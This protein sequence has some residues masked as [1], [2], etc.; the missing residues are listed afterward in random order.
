MAGPIE[1]MTRDALSWRITIPVDGSLPDG[2]LAPTLIQW[3]SQPHPA[4]KL[5]DLGCALQGLEILH[6]RPERMRALLA[7][8]AFDGPVDVRAVPAGGTPCL[9]AHIQTPR[10]PRMLPAAA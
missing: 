9:R 7:A 4:S 6:P 3:D 2:G 10:G 5:P 8:L 1:P